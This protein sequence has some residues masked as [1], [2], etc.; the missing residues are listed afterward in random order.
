MLLKKW[1]PIFIALAMLFVQQ[2]SGQNVALHCDGDDDWLFLP[3]SGT[4]LAGNPATFTIEVWFQAQNVSA[5]A[6]GTR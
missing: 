2:T 6:S 5:S 1:H 4:P 3:L